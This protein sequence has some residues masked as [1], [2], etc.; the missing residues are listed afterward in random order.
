[1]AGWE[2]KEGSSTNR[3]QI[4]SYLWVGGLACHGTGPWLGV[5]QT[6]LKINFALTCIMYL[7]ILPSREKLLW[8]NQIKVG[9]LSP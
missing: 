6:L 9:Y 7:A 3:E 5:G 1:M 4:H 8:S 2:S